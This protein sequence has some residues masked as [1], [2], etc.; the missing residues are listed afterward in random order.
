MISRRTLRQLIVEFS[1]PAM[2]LRMAA[3]AAVQALVPRTSLFARP[4]R[5]FGSRA[6]S[7]AASSSHYSSS[8]SSSSSASFWGALRPQ[9]MR[10][11]AGEA[12]AVAVAV[13]LSL[14]ARRFFGTTAPSAAT[15]K[16]VAAAA[17]T[18]SS[19]RDGAAKMARRAAASKKTVVRQLNLA[20]I[21]GAIAFSVYRCARMHARVCRLS[22]GCGIHWMAAAA[23]CTVGPG[24]RFSPPGL[25]PPTTTVHRHHHFQRRRRRH[26]HHR[27][28]LHPQIISNPP[29]T[30]SHAAP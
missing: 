8:S 21:A 13:A 7:F 24:S 6:S 11:S 30:R 1:P 15:G 25:P 3:T 10:P 20:V 18:A 27:T 5:L 9:P 16:A 23:K 2:A 19:L 26:D 14:P 4:L 12:P 29:Q 17:A 22:N 28:P